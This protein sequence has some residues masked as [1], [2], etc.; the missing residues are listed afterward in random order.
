MVNAPALEGVDVAPGEDHLFWGARGALPPASKLRPRPRDPAT[1]GRSTSLSY[2]ASQATELQHG[3]RACA[4]F[5]RA[6]DPLH[7][8][9]IDTEAFRNDAHTWPPRNRQDLPDA[10]F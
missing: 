1:R 5:G 2:C 6:A 3:D 8:A 7:C 10:C 4:S 9:R